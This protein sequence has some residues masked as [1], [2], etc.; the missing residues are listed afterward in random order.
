MFTY[1][2]YAHYIT[3]GRATELMGANYRV[4]S[5]HV[6]PNLRLEVRRPEDLTQLFAACLLTRTLCWLPA[7]PVLLFALSSPHVP[8]NLHPT[9]PVHQAP[10]LAPIVACML[11]RYGGA[12]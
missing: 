7:Q 12:F 11:W 10:T 2:T 8:P 4:D 3:G 1:V 9:K 5:I 6:K